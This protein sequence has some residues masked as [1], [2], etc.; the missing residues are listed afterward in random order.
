MSATVEPRILTRRD[1]ASEQ[2]VRWCPGCGN[3]AVLAQ[4]QKTLP[5]LG[6][7]RENIVFISGILRHSFNSWPCTHPGHGPEVCAPR[8][9]NLGHHR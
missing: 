3:Y 2:S 6:V 7:A 9:A 5:T 8:A 4:M 1:F